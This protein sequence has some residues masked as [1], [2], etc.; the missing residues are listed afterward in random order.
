MLPPYTFPGDSN[1]GRGLSSF[2]RY[3]YSYTY[4]KGSPPT[5]T[6]TRNDSNVNSGKQVSALAYVVLELESSQS[7]FLAEPFGLHQTRTFVSLPRLRCD[8]IIGGIRRPT[9]AWDFSPG[10]KKENYSNA[11]SAKRL[12]SH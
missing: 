6:L 3:L 8:G 10:S 7:C 12:L 2:I 11:Y 4:G 9:N 5:S 1:I